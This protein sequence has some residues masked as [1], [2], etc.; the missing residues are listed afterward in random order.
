MELAGLVFDMIAIF[1]T[2]LLVLILIILCIG[3]LLNDEK[4]Q[5]ITLFIFSLIYNAV[6]GHMVFLLLFWLIFLLDAKMV[7][8]VCIFAIIL[9][10]INIY[11]M[12]K[13][14]INPILYIIF[15]IIIFMLSAI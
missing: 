3:K 11:M 9:I 13:A 2:P 8:A 7:F 14:K 10:P 6:V 1:C 5:K 15:N 4:A 12:R